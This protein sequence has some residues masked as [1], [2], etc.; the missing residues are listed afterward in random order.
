MCAPGGLCTPGLLRPPGEKQ[1]WAAGGRSQAPAQLPNSGVSQQVG[2]HSLTVTW[3]LT[4][5]RSWAR[6]PRALSS[7]VGLATAT[8]HDLEPSAEA[9]G[10]RLR[11][12]RWTIT[13]AFLKSLAD[14]SGPARRVV[15]RSTFSWA[16][17]P[18]PRP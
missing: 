2:V 4:C 10:G 5:P 16:P 11:L 18:R 6:T 7:T 9:A 8:V 17:A 13:L 12:G 15:K 3:R 14:S 1:G